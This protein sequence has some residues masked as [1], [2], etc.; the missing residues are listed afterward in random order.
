MRLAEEL[1]KIAEELKNGLI[2]ISSGAMIGFATA[3]LLHYM[4]IWRCLP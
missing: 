3:H 4:H 2:N 1:R